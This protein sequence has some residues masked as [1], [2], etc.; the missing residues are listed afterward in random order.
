MFYNISNHPARTENSTWSAEQIAEAN[1]LG[2]EVVD[3]P[4]PT[5]TPEMSDE[6]IADVAREVARAIAF[7]AGAPL[8]GEKFAAMVAGEYVTTIRII[9]ELQKVGVPCYFGQSN[10][11]AEERVEDGKVV[12]VHKFVFAGFRKAPDIELK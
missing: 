5:V 6:R 11:I 9:A 7:A 3:I 2:G 4:F 1:K 10:R 12:V 8:A